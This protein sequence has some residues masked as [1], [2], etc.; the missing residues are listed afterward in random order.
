MSSL[1]KPILGSLIIYVRDLLSIANR[2]SD[3]ERLI[4]VNCSLRML[5]CWGLPVTDE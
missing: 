3:F 1:E 2:H 5:S 4:E